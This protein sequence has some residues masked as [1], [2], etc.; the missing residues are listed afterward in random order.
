MLLVSERIHVGIDLIGERY[1]IG[2][3]KHTGWSNNVFIANFNTMLNVSVNL[4]NG[5]TNCYNIRKRVYHGRGLSRLSP[6]LNYHKHTTVRRSDVSRRRD[7]SRVKG[8]PRWILPHRDTFSVRLRSALTSCQWIERGNFSHNPLPPH[9]VEQS[10]LFI[11]VPELRRGHRPGCSQRKRSMNSVFWIIIWD[12]S[13]MN[14][15]RR[16]F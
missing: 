6:I 4:S 13:R 2:I 8:F 9:L 15:R 14:T 7:E 12:W 1:E 11:I 5:L 16:I 10:P 3:H